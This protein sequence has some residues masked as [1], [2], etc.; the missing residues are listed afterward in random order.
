MLG[1]V[2]PKS[3]SMRV[4]STLSALQVTGA[5]QCK[6][7]KG[8]TRPL[9]DAIGCTLNRNWAVSLWCSPKFMAAHSAPPATPMCFG[10]CDTLCMHPLLLAVLKLNFFGP[11]AV[12]LGLPKG[13]SPCTNITR[14]LVFCLG[15]Y[16][17]LVPWTLGIVSCRPA[18][19]QPT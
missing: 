4:L 12:L 16:Y 1:T 3:M 9:S 13:P 5:P 2:P 18:K 7:T 11:S 15:N 10:P 6:S 19:V 8:L 17:G 14:T